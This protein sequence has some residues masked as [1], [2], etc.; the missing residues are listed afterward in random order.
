MLLL[1]AGAVAWWRSAHGVDEP[2]WPGGAL[3]GGN[4][5]LV[6]IDTLRADR[7]TDAAMPA[8]S[9]LARAGHV[10]RTTYA[11]AP[12]TAPSHA[13]MLTGLLPPA[14][15]VRGNGAFRLDGTHVT[16]AERLKAAGYRTGAFVAAF[17]LDSRFG[18]A[19]GFDR[20]DGVD[21]DR[22]FA[23]DFAFA[24]RRAPGVLAD[25]EAWIAPPTASAQPW[26]AWVHLF[27]PH[28]PYDAPGTSGPHTYNDEVRYADTALG[29]FL[30]RLRRSGALDRTLIV[31]T[32]DHGESLGEHGE[33]THGLFAYDATMRV[34]LVVAG[35]SLGSGAHSAPAAH[36]D[37]VPTI[38]DT[39]GLPADPALPGLSLRVLDAESPRPIYLEAQDGWL[40]AG[41]APVSAVV[42]G[43]L[44]FIDL[45][46][47]ELYDLDT[48]RGETRNVYSASDRRVRAL[49]RVLAS[50]A[51]NPSAVVAP[52]RDSD[53][54]KRLRSLGY[55]SGGARAVPMDFSSADDP[56]RVLPLYERFMTLLAAGGRDADALRALVD[57]RPTFEAARLVA[58]SLLI[59]SGRATEAVRLLE[60]VASLPGATLAVRERLG[61]AH[62][63]AQRPDR[64]VVILE[65]V[66]ADPAASADAWN[67]LG[68]ARAQRGRTSDALSALDTAVG[69]APAAARVRF[70]RALARLAAGDRAGTR[71]D[72]EQVITMQPDFVDAW[73]LLA[74]L[75]HEAGD[76]QSA[77]D[78]WQRVLAIRPNDLD[79]LFNLAVTLA[80]M[81]R[82]DDA[83]AMASRFVEVAP[84]PAWDREAA[85]L[86]PLLVRP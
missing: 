5:L 49:E 22:T 67:A 11:H 33:S 72:A 53:T 48:D 70:N 41:A 3:V 21:D 32:A 25:A 84:R 68:V 62:L 47:P 34:P 10:F 75:G 44:K 1:L 27:D 6:T 74:T 59:E 81:G 83:R 31:V 37:L 78:A 8:L 15:G 12:L 2:R 77:V 45:P 17:V 16:L 18:L 51:A 23:T 86:G 13:S 24:E 4:V 54:E 14:H 57:A 42:S 82:R 30:G 7:L 65:S 66:V 71:V 20:Y 36:I 58:A 29:E 76:R 26:F 85:V 28:A 73:R 69:L 52:P 79:T 50:I 38:L 63:S 39:L 80:E 60:P 46:E 9:A 19:Q 43:H 40:A 56:K 61:T 64:A 55:T 35:P